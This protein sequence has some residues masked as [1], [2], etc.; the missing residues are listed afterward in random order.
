MTTKRA[1]LGLGATGGIGGEMARALR[2]RGWSVRALHRR[3]EAMATRDGLDWRQGDAMEAADVARAAEGV[4][5]IVHAVNPPGYRNW[6]RLV[7]PMLESSIAASRATDARIVLP[8]TVY[9]FGPEALPLLTEASPQNPVTRRR[10]VSREH[11]SVSRGEGR[12]RILPSPRE[13][14]ERRLSGCLR[15]KS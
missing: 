10:P 8:G 13:S 9:N 2:R 14:D 15:C 4:E 5:L 6:G 12:A 7:L 11:V 3:A 1:A